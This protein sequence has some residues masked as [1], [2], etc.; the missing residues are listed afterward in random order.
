M[1]ESFQHSFPI[2]VRQFE[3]Q[4][5]VTHYT[6]NILVT[7]SDDRQGFIGPKI[8][9]V[10]LL[11]VSDHLSYMLS[12]LKTIEMHNTELQELV[13]PK[14]GFNRRDYL[15]DLRDNL[16]LGYSKII[17]DEYPPNTADRKLLI[18]TNGFDINIDILEIEIAE[19][20][21]SL[22]KNMKIHPFDIKIELTRP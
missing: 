11:T 13:E 3:D 9:T 4:T 17:G 15:K 5:K 19:T 6:C 18:V 12:D 14:N 1:I 2:V 16:P 10:K 20:F 8:S 7:P 22:A 21:R